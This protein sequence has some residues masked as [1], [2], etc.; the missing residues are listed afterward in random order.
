MIRKILVFPLSV[1][2]AWIA[3]WSSASVWA[4][5]SLPSARGS[6]AAY[7]ESARN[8]VEQLRQVIDRSH[9]DVEALIEALGWDPEAIIRFV[10]K[11]VEFEQYPG[12]LRGAKGTLMSRAGN[13]LDQALLLAILLKYGNA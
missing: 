8:T 9:F 13:S 4:Q 6:A 10:G 5:A 1:T 11:E 7:A 2:I 3:G 12:L